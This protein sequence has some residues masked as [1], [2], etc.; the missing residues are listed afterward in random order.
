[1]A[2][3]RRFIWIAM[4]ETATGFERF[5]DYLQW[6]AAQAPAGWPGAV[7][8]ILR[9]GEDCAGICTRD[10][11]RPV[12]FL[13]QMAAAPPVQFGATGFSPALTDDSNPA[14]HYVAFVVVGFWLPIP[15]AVAVLYAWEVAGFVRY[16]GYWS[17]RDVASG[18]VGIRHGRA[19]RRLGPSVLPGLT[20]ALVDRAPARSQ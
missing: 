4:L 20:A 19:V 1:M 5:L 6:M 13:R 15:L 7:W 18:Q 9:I 8:F 3:L 10:M 16:G 14:R 2:T 12:R 11:V 17:P